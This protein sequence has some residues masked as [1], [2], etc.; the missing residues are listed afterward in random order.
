MRLHRRPSCR[1]RRR[2]S[3]RIIRYDP[4]TGA[5]RTIVRNLLF[6]NGICMAHDNK[7]V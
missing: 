2:P 6:A 7:S 3:G 4:A 1:C 5:T